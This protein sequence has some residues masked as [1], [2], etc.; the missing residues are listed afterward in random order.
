MPFR[1]AT[2]RAATLATALALALAAC[3]TPAPTNPPTGG[4]TASARPIAE[5]YAEIRTQ[6]EQIRGFTPTADVEPVTIDE[7]QLLENFTTEFDKAQTPEQLKDGED[8]L[9]AL[10]LLPAGSSLRDLTLDFS[11]GQIAG[12]Y[13]PLKDELFVVSRGTAPGPAEEVTYA[14][15]YT[16]QLQDQ[17]TDIDDLD[18]D[19]LDQ[20]DRALAMRAIVEG[21]ATSVQQTW[22]LSNLTSK[23]LGEVLAAGLDPDAIEALRRAPRYLR[24]TTTFQY[25]DG[26]AL[27]TRLLAEGGYDAV[28]KA[29][30]DPPV[31]TEQVLHPDKYL[32]REAPIEVQ[33]PDEMR[34]TDAWREAARDTLGELIL[35]IWLRENGVTLAEARTASAGWGGDRLAFLRGPNGGAAVYLVTEWDSV[36]DAE[37]FAAAA[38]IVVAHLALGGRMARERGSTTV[39]VLIGDAWPIAL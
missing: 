5:I 32:Q 33:L 8:L 35:R 22:M 14:H 23:E 38:Q 15:E 16:H 18:L 1:R 31:S 29:I 36:P 25:E 10:G 21:D 13:D 2:R 6:V 34:P 11:A 19:A 9:I 7:Q 24:E 28:T 3:N 26:L 30:G 39:V 37:E 27:V 12:Y 17:N 4:P 20:S